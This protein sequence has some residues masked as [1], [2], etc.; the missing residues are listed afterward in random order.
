MLTRPD[1]ADAIGLSRR[2]TDYNLRTSLICRC[3]FPLVNTRVCVSRSLKVGSAD[4][5]P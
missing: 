1:W 3:S 4:S 5:V 2:Q